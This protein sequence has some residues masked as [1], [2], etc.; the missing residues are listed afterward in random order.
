MIRTSRTRAEIADELVIAAFV[1][2]RKARTEGCANEVTDLLFQEIA[3]TR[4]INGDRYSVRTCRR[5]ARQRARDMGELH[6]LTE[7]MR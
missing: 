4:G 1:F 6:L 3:T 2:V 5:L 7:G